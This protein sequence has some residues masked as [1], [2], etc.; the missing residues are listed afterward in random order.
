MRNVYLKG[1][2]PL[3]FFAAF[4]VIMS[5]G[6]LSLDKITNAGISNLTF[7][8]RGGDAVEF[9]YVLSGFLITFLLR[10]EIDKTG[11]VSIRQFYLRRIFRIWPLY[12]LVVVIGFILL[13]II[14]P[15]LA[16]QQ[17]FDF[18]LY[19]GLI[20]FL[21]FLPNMATSLY[22]TGLLFPLRT[23]GVEE[24]FYL[25][26][27]PLIKASRKN[28]RLL[29]VVFIL[30][31]YIGY[32]WLESARLEIAEGLRGFLETLKFYAMATGAL[33]GLVYHRFS[34]QI[35][36]SW[37]CSKWMQCVIFTTIGWYYLA[38]IPLLDGTIGHF[39]LCWLYGLLIFNSCIPEKPV[40]NLEKRPF[41]YLG[42]ISY[43]LYCCHMIVDY[44]LRFVVMRFH[45]ERIDSTILIP[46]YL[47]VLVG[48][49]IFLAG[50]S[51]KYYESYYLRLKDKVCLATWRLSTIGS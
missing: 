26:W 49:A 50:L 2:N 19:K 41:I 48:G 21:C 23:I 28:T 6:A 15:R 4:F 32:F 11:T 14:Y 40:F 25:F 38:G 33:F 18:P 51:Y 47:T 45:L 42:A 36:N 30:V 37:L 27:A 7:F 1:L 34:E 43:G 20:L 16:G 8:N 46:L 13:G 12:F 5:H 10:R 3:R 17:F 44:I 35:R 9:F 39:F 31:S 22:S 29:I 24:Q